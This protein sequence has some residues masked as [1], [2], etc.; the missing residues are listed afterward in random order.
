MLSIPLQN[1]EEWGKLL[2][3]IDSYENESSEFNKAILELL[4]DPI[5]AQKEKERKEKEDL[6]KQEF[7]K[8]SYEN[9]LRL[10]KTRKISS[11]MPDL[12]ETDEEGHLYLK[13]YNTPI[14]KLLCEKLLEAHFNPNSSFTK[15]SLINFWK[16]VLLN[17]NPKAQADLFDW[18]ATGE[19]TITESG[20][21]VAYRC[22]DIKQS[23]KNR[24]LYEYVAQ[25]YMKIKKQKKS[26]KNFN[27]H[28]KADGGFFCMPLSNTPHKGTKD[29]SYVGNLA[30]LY[31]KSLEE[32]EDTTIY[33]DH[34]T[35]SMQIRM[36]IPVSLPIEFCDQDAENQCSR[37]LHGMSPSYGLR[38]G[39][40]AI[41]ILVCPSKIIAFPSYDKT[42][43]RCTEYLPL[44]RVSMEGKKID[45]FEEGTFD[46]EYNNYTANVLNNLFAQYTPQQMQDKG[47]I[48]QEVD[49]EDIIKVQLSIKEIINQRVCSVYAD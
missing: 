47:I 46:F 32:K 30:D 38:Y 39:E 34:H 25:Q 9:N 19:F 21:I 33:T 49:V 18:F 26:P 20:M 40:V 3:A 6:A 7:E 41:M 12:F 45:N 1:D 16:W 24:D 48:S 13:G 29:K 17:P 31:T 22:V 36:G 10:R 15:T 23:S 14:P 27:I 11:V 42:K 8:K 44:G 28:N 43:F 37:G 5:A 35:G 2:V 4:L